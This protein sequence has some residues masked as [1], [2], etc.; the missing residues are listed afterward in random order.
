MRDQQNTTRLSHPSQ[1]KANEAAVRYLLATTEEERYEAFDHLMGICWKAK[2]NL[3]ATPAVLG[4][5]E[6]HWFQWSTFEPTRQLL[7]EL[8]LQYLLDYQDHCTRQEIAQLASIGEFR[9]LP[10]RVKFKMVDRIRAY[11]RLKEDGRRREPIELSLNLVLNEGSDSTPV[12]FH[13]IV[14]SGADRS[15]LSDH[16]PA[17]T[18]LQMVE[19]SR[20]EF[21]GMVGESN[22]VV[23]Q[24]AA[25]LYPDLGRNRR[26]RKSR[27]TNAVADKAGI[28]KQWARAKIRAVRERLGYIPITSSDSG[29]RALL[30]RLRHDKWVPKKRITD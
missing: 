25:G 16:I 8:I 20:D 17:Q 18:I 4:R 3:Y 30:K 13:E 10:R 15:Y 22:W 21:V 29:V 24:A 27:L 9:H 2:G 14:P 23:I 19:E 6:A 1:N 28:S 5:C 7:E 12:E 11:Y 26:E